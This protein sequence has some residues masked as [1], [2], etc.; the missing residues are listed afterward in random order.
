[1]CRV[2]WR[3]LKGASRRIGGNDILDSIT[4][5][6]QVMEDEAGLKLGLWVCLDAEAVHT[7]VR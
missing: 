5:Y 1:M 4:T 3:K 2:D 6:R 7:F